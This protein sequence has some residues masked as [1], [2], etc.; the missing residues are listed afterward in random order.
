MSANIEQAVERFK[1]GFN[2]CQAVVGSYCEQF[3][4]DSELAFK[5]ATGFGGGMRMG[6]TCGAVTGA[7]MVLGLKYGNTTAEDKE[8]KAKTYKMVVEYTNRFKA[9][10]G[11]VMCKELLGIDISTD[12][13]LQSFMESGL[14]DSVCP[15][16]IQDAGL[17]AGLAGHN[18]RVF[19]WAEEHADADFYMCS[20]YNPTRREK[21]P[22]HQHG[23]IEAFDAAA[24]DAM[25]ETIKG[26]S[27]PAIHYKVLAAGRN[28]P[29]ETFAF[30][31]RHLRPNDAA[32]VGIYAAE[33][34]N[35]MQEDIDL[36]MG[37]IEKQEGCCG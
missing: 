8:S 31:A 26:L 14:H 24:R 36:L 5:V 16:M 32:C 2:C 18:P 37:A 7:F 21:N 22:G 23:A 19:E 9:R 29:A 6:E 35:M 28:D 13:G 15:K 34:P 3:G 33:K 30:V 4:L 11:S 17:P 27:K 12:Q 10:N 1:N 25:V 20:Y